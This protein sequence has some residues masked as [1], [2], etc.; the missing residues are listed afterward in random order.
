VVL[1]A[2]LAGC[3]PVTETGSGKSVESSLDAS[4]SA[5]PTAVSVVHPEPK[6]I[7][8]KVEG[9]QCT[10][11]AYEQTM[12]YARIP[13]YVGKVHSDIGQT[14]EPGQVLAELS[15]PEMDEE[16]N[17]KKALVRQTEADVEQ[18]RKALAAA[19][20]SIDTAGAYVEETR[21]LKERWESESKRIA[22]LVGKGVMDTQSAE[23]TRNQFKAATARLTSAEAAVKKAVA[24][25][26]KAQADVRSVQARVDV[27]SAEARRLEALQGYAKIRAP[28]RGVVTMRKVNTG[29]F[30]QP[31]GSQGNWL[32]TVARLDPLRIVID[33]PQ[34]A[35]GLVREGV[36]MS[37]SIKDL[38]R[39]GLKG[40]VSRT[41]WALTPGSRLLRA[42][43]DLTD[44]EGSLRP[45]MFGDASTTVEQSV[46]WALPASALLEQGQ[47]KVCYLV[48]GGKAVRTSVRA[49]RRDGKFTEVLQYQKPGSESW[50]GWTGQEAVVAR[51]AEVSDGQAVAGR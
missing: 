44:K 17:Q 28:F 50:V 34:E 30:V 20:A 47:A 14:V 29:D 45:G 36:E 37:L 46:K 24:D 5:S 1:A 11:E 10:V 42:E 25:R 22:G 38:D 19:E 9:M 2:A 12:L 48:Q 51:A 7:A 35:A 13:G 4:L 39:P 8:V 43:I 40:K 33:V 23:E 26:D 3:R 41:S 21:A 16:V 18:A 15:V 32:F 6:T 27:A 31:A 49:G